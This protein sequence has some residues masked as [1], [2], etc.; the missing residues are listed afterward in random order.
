MKN[1]LICINSD[2]VNRYGFMI[3]ITALEKSLKEVYD[4]GMPMLIGHDFHRPIGWILPF[5][6]FIEPKLSR[7]IASK[8][9]AE[10]G[11][12]IFKV[13]NALQNFLGSKYNERFTDY[14][15]E[16]LKLLNG[17]LTDE[18][19]VVDSG[20]V[21]I[22]DKGI[23]LKMFS[24]IFDKSDDIGLINLKDLLSDFD[25]LGQGIFKN[26]YSP[27][28]LYAHRY[29]RRSQSRHNNFHFHFLDA[30]LDLKD[31]KNLE[32]KLRMDKGMIGF[33]PSFHQ[34]GELEFHYGP[35]YTDDISSIKSGISRYQTTQSERFYTDVS[36]SEFYWKADENDK[37]FEM[38]EL[39]D[40]PSFAEQ[41]WYHCRYIHSIFNKE[42]N[43]FFHFDGAIRSYDME[44]M[45]DRVGKDFL[46]YGRKAHY[47][48]LFR[49]DGKIELNIWKSLI[50][51]YL[52][53]NP[54]IYEY[55]GV[56]QELEKFRIEEQPLSKYEK[57]LPFKISKEEGLRLFIS[58]HRPPT[59]IA[60]GR[61]I[62]IFDVMSAGESPIYCL[63]HL[64]LEVQR[65]LQR[66]GGDL[67]IP[68]DI[69]LTKCSDGF[70]NIPSIMHHGD[71][72]QH[73][74]FSTVEAFKNLFGSMIEKKADFNI[75][76]TLSFV[77]NGRII[78]IS[79]FGYIQNQ[80]NWLYSNFP[81]EFSETGITEWVEKQRNYLN[82]FKR[83]DNDL[84]ISQLV[85]NDGILYIKRIP[86]S[87][88]YEYV[89][90]EIGLK[91]LIKFP[92]EGECEEYELFN[93]G[94]IRPVLH[95]SIEKAVW[96]D[97]KENYFNSKRS[98]W[99]DDNATGVEIVE[100]TPLALYWA[101]AE[102]V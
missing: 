76:L 89:D 28:A 45:L 71:D 57:L 16:F 14:K 23:A 99:L 59:D 43:E 48:K 33:A 40:D 42:N 19:M 72:V 68:A 84:L 98:K 58:Y 25:Y 9:V 27:L 49:V 95:M 65:A 22:V 51:H 87:F 24:G 74:L 18:Y 31:E 53:G 86:V 41:D 38:E 20:C 102:S 70:W 67:D 34:I 100:A 35:K 55:F 29:F 73:L 2:A 32:I 46:E 39:K 93:D 44:S 4:K 64:I 79:S 17:H 12:E 78:R 11:D 80:L 81:F 7:V 3:T 15:D 77:F 56:A 75:S 47:K 26:K 63:E 8:M 82:S 60:T 21:A 92:K 36:A 101:R 66:V 91:Y 69:V 30:L 1:E 90:D 54:L 50:T 13:Q 61:Y 97:T 6:I 94:K 96:A 85:Q 37:T 88:T 5:G 10:N 83:S 62:D 52:Q